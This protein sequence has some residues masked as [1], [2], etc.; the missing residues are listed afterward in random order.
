MDIKIPEFAD[1]DWL[2]DQLRDLRSR[3]EEIINVSGDMDIDPADQAGECLEIIDALRQ[4]TG[5]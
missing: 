3:V 2:R 1:D 5:Y 4:Y